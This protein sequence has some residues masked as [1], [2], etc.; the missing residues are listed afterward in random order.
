MCVLFKDVIMQKLFIN[1]NYIFTNRI[2]GRFS[3]RREK[4][5]RHASDQTI[6]PVHFRL[7]GFPVSFLKCKGGWIISALLHI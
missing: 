3:L 2:T 6:D 5:I 4:L 1:I 7:K